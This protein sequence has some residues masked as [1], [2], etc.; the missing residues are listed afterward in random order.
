MT[1]T[2]KRASWGGEDLTTLTRHIA[3]ADRWLD[4]RDRPWDDVEWTERSDQTKTPHLKNL[5]LSKLR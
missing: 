4:P 5:S 2:G 1:G 3:V